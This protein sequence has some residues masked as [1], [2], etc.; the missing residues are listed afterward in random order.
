MRRNKKKIFAML[1]FLL[2]SLIMF[3]SA[4]PSGDVEGIQLGKP[5]L[6]VDGQFSIEVFDEIPEF[7][8]VAKDANGNELKV[9]ITHSINNQ[10]LGTYEVRFKAEDLDG[11]VI[12]EK[13]DFLVVDTTRPIISLRGRALVK[14]ILGYE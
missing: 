4:N 6:D 13:R 8:A 10:V 12:E 9:D 5:S 3:A 11:N 7:K 14:R 1:I 2:M